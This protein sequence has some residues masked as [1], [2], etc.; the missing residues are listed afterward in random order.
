M[1]TAHHELPQP[2]EGHARPRACVLSQLLQR[3]VLLWCLFLVATSALAVGA[4]TLAPHLLAGPAGLSSL[5]AGLQLVLLLM[6]VPFAV[7][8]GPP[9]L[10]L[11]P[12][13]GS[14]SF[15][16]LVFPA[17]TIAVGYTAGIRDVD[18]SL[19]A[20]AL[21]SVALAGLTEELAFRGILLDRLRTCHTLWPA[22]LISSALFGL[23]HL[24]NLALGASP[25]TTLLQVTFAALAGTGYAAMRIRT[26]SLWPPIIL[27]ALFDLTFRIGAVDPG[28]WF[29]H[30]IHLLHGVGWLVYALIVLRPNRQTPDHLR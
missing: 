16:V 30:T 29:T 2:T 8:T 21:A 24:S 12:V 3:P 22:V 23:M 1:N 20:L 15:A 14:R 13:T 6:V 19:L 18:R 26:G 7:A 9:R 17:L 11:V 25:G 27:H 28:T 10:G 4:K 5:Q